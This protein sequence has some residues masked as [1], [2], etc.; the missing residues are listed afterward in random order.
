MAGDFEVLRRWEA[1]GATWRVLARTPVRL[2][3]ALLS[4]DAGEQ[5]GR[6]R[7]TE[8]DLRAYIGERTRSDDA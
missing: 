5:V 1:S 3:I 8:P 7:S 6:L 4:C 2:D